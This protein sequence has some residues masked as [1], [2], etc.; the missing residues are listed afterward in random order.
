MEYDVF[1]C[2]ASEDKES[3]VK[4]LAAN[5]QAKGLSVWY[6]EFTLRLGDSL[7]ES[8]SKGLAGSSYGIVIISSHFI[9][10]KWPKRELAALIAREDFADKVILPIWHGISKQE[11]VEH[12]PLLADKL[13]VK[14]EEG[15]E[16]IS[17]KI[18]EVVSPT[19]LANKKYE[20]GLDYEKKGDSNAAVKYYIDALRI[21]ADHSPALQQ[22]VRLLNREVFSLEHT[23]IV[24]GY[25]KKKTDKGFGFILG[26][27]GKDY[28]FHSRSLDSSFDEMNEG[29]KTVFHIAKGSKGEVAVTVRNLSL[30]AFFKDRKPGPDR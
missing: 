14:S 1:I 3:F 24:L 13:A 4:I 8:I 10:K 29:D 26:E 21:D 25:V 28:F 22:I 16:A 11:V 17:Q 19:R 9:A 6:D 2:H 20:Q 27:D 15:I 30:S 18:L 12:L 7:S 23:L 5:L